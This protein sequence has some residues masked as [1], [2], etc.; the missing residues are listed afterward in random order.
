MRILFV[1]AT[2][3]LLA[4]YPLSILDDIKS[5]FNDIEA[6]FISYDSGFEERDRSDKAIKKIESFENYNL[7]NGNFFK[8]K[9]I[10]KIL[11]DLKPDLVLFGGYRLPDML[12]IA[13][14]NLLKYKTILL[15]HGFDIDHIK[16][17]T[18]GMFYNVKKNFN[19]LKTLIQYS[20]IIEEPFI[21]TFAIYMRHL[22]FGLKLFNTRIGVP[23]GWPTKFLIYSD[24]YRKLFFKKYGIEKSRMKVIGSIDVYNIL[25]ISK[26]KRIHS[27]CYLAQTFVEDN[28]MSLKDFK[29]LILFYSEL[30]AKL[31]SFYI[32]MHPRS[33]ISLFS[34][35][36]DL[37]NVKIINNYFPSCSAYIGHYSSTLFT[38]SYLSRCIIIHEIDNE[39]IPEIYKSCANLISKDINEIADAIV[40]CDSTIP[41]ID[42]VEEK[43]GY[44][45]PMPKKNPISLIKDEI[46]KII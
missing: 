38:A 37:S 41:G 39:P 25:N 15:Q 36:I 45:A 19:Y 8:R 26:N 22:F 11:D 14:C 13:I 42:E 18:S 12:W 33:N 31:D 23:I 43:I 10:E 5:D 21:V 32:K 29:K 24:Y 1:D 44:I 30:A 35:L 6:F 16:R 9:S 34:E 27:A 17:S 40:N 2:K 20:K 4:R 7:I 28:R 46:I 3:S